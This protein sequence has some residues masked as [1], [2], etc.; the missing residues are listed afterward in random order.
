M[1][2]PPITRFRSDHFTKDLPL[3]N[4]LRALALSLFF[5]PSTASAEEPFTQ[6]KI[7]V[8]GQASYGFWLGDGELNGYMLGLG[9]SGGYTLKE[10]FYF[11]GRF[12]YFLGESEENELLGTDV[13]GNLWKIQ[14]E[15]GYDIGIS[16]VLVVRPKFGVGPMQVRL[17]SCQDTPTGE[18]CGTVTDNGVGFA[19]GAELPI[20]AGPVVISPDLRFNFYSGSGDATGLVFGIHAGMMF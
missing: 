12:D 10:N 1:R 18:A 6:E 17:K 20:N 4:L 3:K 7:L 5:L 8:T 15:V 19:M 16:D 9:L 14:A 2:G 13:R 11:G